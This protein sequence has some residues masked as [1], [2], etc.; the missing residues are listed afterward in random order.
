VGAGG[1]HAHGEPALRR[2]D[3]SEPSRRRPWHATQPGSL[4]GTVNKSD[5]SPRHAGHQARRKARGAVGARCP[6][7]K[8]EWVRRGSCTAA[9]YRTFALDRLLGARL[10][11]HGQSQGGDAP[12]A[13]AASLVA[14]QPCRSRPGAT[15]AEAVDPYAGLYAEPYAGHPRTPLPP[16]GRITA[17]HAHYGG[18]E[19]PH[20]VDALRA[21]D[22]SARPRSWRT[23]GPRRL[24]RQSQPALVATHG[25]AVRTP[26]CR[27]TSSRRVRHRRRHEREQLR[28]QERCRRW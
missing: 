13:R 3:V 19:R 1:W 5:V 27:S 2:Q 8:G 18:V 23:V 24:R 12:S 7:V 26:C 22:S 14:T 25:G 17:G 10:A 28:V 6:A 20:R 21:I 4:P 11:G 16:G 9:G 15:V